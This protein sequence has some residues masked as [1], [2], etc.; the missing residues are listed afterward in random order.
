M[1]FTKEKYQEFIK[2]LNNLHD[3]KYQKFQQRL[4]KDE[5]IKIIGV[6]TPELKKIAKQISKE[7][8]LSFIKENT[9]QTYEES[10]LHGLVLGYIKTNEDNL[11]K[12]IDDFIPYINNWATNDL[13]TSNL[14]AFK[15]IPINK[16]FKYLKSSNPWEIRF[17][18]TLLLSYYIKE[19]NLEQIYQIC[20]TINSTHYYVNM[21]IAWL[22][23]I[24]YIK[25]PNLTFNYLK[26]C[27]L[28]KF[29]LN[30]TISKICDSYRVSKEAKESVKSLRK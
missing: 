18:L 28:D 27:N 16:T 20:D 30:K 12:L 26:K 4:L 29:T 19:E 6:R 24:C 11:L 17:G 2:Q 9:H 25:Y 14:K 7:D 15:H 13:T 23:S 22:L 8:Y 1:S 21:A 3:E 5:K 10:L